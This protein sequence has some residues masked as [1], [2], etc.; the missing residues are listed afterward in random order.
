MKLK[1]QISDIINKD[2]ERAERIKKY[3]E[4]LKEMEEILRKARYEEALKEDSSR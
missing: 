4:E 3:K 1:V 2:I